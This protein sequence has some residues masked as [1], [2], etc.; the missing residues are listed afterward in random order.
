MIYP[1]A[2]IFPS[3]L[4]VIYKRAENMAFFV[5]GRVKFICTIHSFGGGNSAGKSALLTS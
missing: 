2:P 5:D 1:V 3:R 4:I